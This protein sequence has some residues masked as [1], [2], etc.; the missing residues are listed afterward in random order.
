MNESKTLVKHIS[1]NYRCKYE[2]VISDKCKN[3]LVIN[4]T[5]IIKSKTNH[6]YKEGLSSK[7]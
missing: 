4:V 7:S 3:G 5:V 1:Y 6:I 2:N